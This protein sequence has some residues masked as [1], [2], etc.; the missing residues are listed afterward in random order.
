[1]IVVVTGPESSGKTTLA[2]QLAEYFDWPLLPELAREYLTGKSR[3]GPGDLLTLA[4][5]QA[6]SEA[7]LDEH[8]ILD[9]DWQT[10]YIW[11]QEKFGPAPDSLVQRYANAPRRMYLLCKPDLPWEADAL[12][13]NPDDRDRL[14]DL[15]YRDC[16]NRRLSWAPVAGLAEARFAAALSH[17]EPWL[18]S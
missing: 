18:K 17:I 2:N 16:V 15:Y 6:A 13:E 14:F 1:M 4:K 10:L 5:Q 8:G 9:T 7:D 12:R 3:Y 11:W